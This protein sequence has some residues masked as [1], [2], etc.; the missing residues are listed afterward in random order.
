MARPYDLRETEEYRELGFRIVLCPV[1][2]KETLDDYFICPTCAWEYDG[3]T[4]EN[5]YSSCNKATI[6]D[7]RKTYNQRE[8]QSLEVKSNGKK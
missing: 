4:E 1:C 5:E 8:I 2:G 7:Y 6:S 3:T